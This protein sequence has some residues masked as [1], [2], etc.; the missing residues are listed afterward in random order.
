[1][2]IVHKKATLDLKKLN[3]LENKAKKFFIFE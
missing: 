3:L 1:M 2:I